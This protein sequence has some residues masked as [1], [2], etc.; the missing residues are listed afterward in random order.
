MKI[1]HL[2]GIRIQ[3]LKKTPTPRTGNFMGMPITNSTFPDGT[4]LEGEEFCYP[5]GGMLRRAYA[6]CE[7]GIKRV[8]ECGIADT[9]FS[10]PA[11]TKGAKGFLSVSTSGSLVFKAF[12]AT[13]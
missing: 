10:I 3:K 2:R 9:F 11:R 8:C 12:K 6:V 4:W 5:T 13:S 7:D 1:N